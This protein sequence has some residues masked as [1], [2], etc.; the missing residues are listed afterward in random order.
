MKTY[1]GDRNEVIVG[2]ANG[3]APD[4]SAVMVIARTSTTYGNGVLVMRA[5]DG[6]NWTSEFLPTTVAMA[7]CAYDSINNKI[8]VIDSVSSANNITV[9]ESTD[10]GATWTVNTRSIGDSGSSGWPAFNAVWFDTSRSR[11]ILSSAS[12]IN[13]PVGAIT[14]LQSNDGGVTW[15]ALS[16]NQVDNGTFSG[17][18]Y[19]P[20]APSPLFMRASAS[21]GTGI[22]I[23]KSNTTDDTLEEMP[24]VI[25]TIYPVSAGYTIAYSPL[26]RT[27]VAPNGLTSGS[28]ATSISFSLDPD[29]PPRQV[30]VISTNLNSTISYIVWSDEDS[31]FFASCRADSMSTDPTL[32][33]TFKSA[34]GNGGWI[35]D[36]APIYNT[37]NRFGVSMFYDGLRKLVQIYSHG[38]TAAQRIQLGYLGK[39]GSLPTPTPTP[40]SSI[41]PTPSPINQ[42]GLVWINRTPASANNWTAVAWSTKSEIFAAVAN[43]GTNNN[44][45]MT[46]PDGIV[47]THPAGVSNTIAWADITYSPE[48]DRFVAVANG[49]IMYSTGTGAWTVN[50]AAPVNGGNWISVEWSPELSLFVAVSIAGTAVVTSPDGITWTARTASKESLL[51][52]SLA[53]SPAL[54]LF[55]A[56]G[57]NN[58][59]R[60]A[61][62]SPDGINWTVRTTTSLSASDSWSKIVWSPELGKFVAIGSTAVNNVIASLI[63]S[64]GINWTINTSPWSYAASQS[65][66]AIAWSPELA[67]FVILAR[68]G[69]RRTATSVDGVNWSTWPDP[70]A[71]IKANTDVVWSQRRFMFVAVGDASVITG[72]SSIVPVPTPTPTVTATITPSVSL[73]STP[74]PTPSIT[75]TS[76][77]MPS[78]VFIGFSFNFAPVNG[79]TI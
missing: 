25:D 48:L 40:T 18:A 74:T 47:W 44:K 1:I 33:R 52:L 16:T 49:N 11:L 30:T 71:D 45:V 54:G 21:S 55:V 68:S 31:Q 41:T 34:Y 58:G 27:Y 69:T 50:A 36:P 37:Q 77:P 12:R 32:Y 46:S 72:Q 62:T 51:V 13:L 6:L 61:M 67:L 35:Y 23:Y 39:A 9:R 4:G 17:V 15:T 42:G 60:N 70:V 53:W 66:T 3:I 24:D 29:G 38:Y 57:T 73:S 8:F 19:A 5:Q 7:G 20:G 10:F 2:R 65:W 63:S 26:S 43:S 78:P 64:D 28:S 75:P 56:T 59:D 76:T 14:S 22:S 79:E